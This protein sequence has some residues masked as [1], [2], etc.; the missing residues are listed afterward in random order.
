MSVR[1]TLAALLATTLIAVVMPAPMISQT[2]ASRAP[3][4]STGPLS[5]PAA[6]S[7]A[8]A[9]WSKEQVAPALAAYRQ[10]TDS[11][12]PALQKAY[13]AA[14]NAAS[15]G[16]Q[17]MATECAA[18]FSVASVPAAELMD[19]IALYNAARDTANS[20]LATERVMT[21][22]NLPPRVHGQALMLAMGQESTKDPSYFG[23]IAGAERYVAQIDALPD[24]LDDIKLQAHQRMLGRYEYLDVAEGLFHHATAVIALGRKLGMK[25][26]MIAGYSSLAR[27]FAD[28]LNPDSA[29]KILDT[30]ER[31]IGAAAAERFKD[32]RNRYALIG[33]Q[34]PMISAEWWINPDSKGVLTPAPGK[35]TL[36]EFTAHWCGPCKNSY[37]G[38]HALSERLKGKPFTGLMV[39]Q[40]YG[41]LGTRQNL[42][43]EQEVAADREYF[44]TEHA[45]P[46]PVA[47]NPPMKQVVGQ[48]YAQPKPDTDYRVG[49]IPQIMI[50]DKKGIIRQI[51]TGWDQGNTERFSKFIDQ[52]ISEKM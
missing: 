1:P 3:A 47:I 26:E 6:C 46:F 44:G 52:L 39:T 38:L 17:K 36:V 4:V 35:V 15:V 37:P 30:G 9:D 22:K 48:P 14:Y 50:I 45:L 41:Y 16:S 49:G 43:P 34:A 27:S 51:V 21:E 20:R 32:F 10:A 25:Q 18:K 24:S 23:I 40:L 11:T 12:R 19:L 5:P 42:S 8:A 29:L 13:V 7:K 33:T 28:R 31:E 2:M